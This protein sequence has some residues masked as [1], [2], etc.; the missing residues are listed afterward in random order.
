MHDGLLSTAARAIGD[1]PTPRI[2]VLS[3]R[4]DPPVAARL[5]SIEGAEVHGLRIADGVRRLHD[6]L[7]IRGPFDLIVDVALGSD[8]ARRG[9]A[10]FL[11]TRRDGVYVARLPEEPGARHEVDLLLADYAANRDRPARFPTVA[12]LR[13]EG[14]CLVARNVVDALP[15][16]PERRANDFLDRLDAGHRVVATVPAV[17]WPVRSDVRASSVPPLNPMP[18]TYDAPEVSL[19]EYADVTCVPR[20]GAFTDRFVLPESFRRSLRPRSTSGAFADLGRGFV[21]RPQVETV[22][23]PG[24][25]FHLDPEIPEHFGHALTEQVSHLWGW[26]EARRRHPELRALVFAPPSGALP[27]WTRDLLAAGGVAPAD[28]HVAHRPVRVQT[29]LATSPLYSI[30]DFVHPHIEAT[31]HRIGSALAAGTA[32]RD[33]PRR[34]FLTRTSAKRGCTNRS[35]VEALFAQAGFAVVSPERHRLAD[36][37]QLV[38]NADVVAGFAGSGLLQIAFAGGPKHV[39]AILPDTYAAHNEYQLSALLGH[40]LDL[41][42]CRADVPRRAAGFDRAAY[43]STF[44]VDMDAEGAWLRQVLAGL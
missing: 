13:I 4:P 14:G 7:T 43:R 8:V 38:R 15:R 29:L 19:R 2:A 26:E 21:V 9:R 39:I 3:R 6:E 20:Q 37:V 16:I 41:V 22:T 33:R 31:Y 27:D 10:L 34:A 32:A 24:A 44:G 28:L 42:V 12:E 11:H 5:G 35:E 40:R 25:F 36:Q 30:R 17:T 23:L 18:T 1:H